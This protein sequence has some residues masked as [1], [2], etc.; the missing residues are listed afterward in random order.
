MDQ[1]MKNDLDNYITGHYGEDQFKNEKLHEY[2]YTIYLNEFEYKLLVKI[3]RRL[4]TKMLKVLCP[5]ETKSG[6]FSLLWNAVSECA[7]KEVTR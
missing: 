4:T 1:R 7:K 6:D 2:S 3:L 5:K